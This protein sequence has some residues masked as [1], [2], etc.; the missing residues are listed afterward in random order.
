MSG[1]MR[2]FWI[3]LALSFAYPIVQYH[4]L[5]GLPWSQ[6]PLSTFNKGM[7]LGSILF[8]ALSY[9]AGPAR[10]LGARWAEGLLPMRKFLGLTGFTLAAIHA[11][12]SLLILTPSYYA[13]FFGKDGK[14][15]TNAELALLFGVLAFAVFAVVAAASIPSMFEYLGKK[16]WLKVQQYGYLG[17]LLVLLH[18]AAFGYAG[19]FTPANWQ[20]GILPITLVGFIIGAIALLLKILATIFGEKQKEGK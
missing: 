14:F 9:F 18:A 11:C 1:K 12:I 8:I 3:G 2:V 13:R 10:R 16:Q 20:G 6:F 19:W 5:R 4:F 7:A 15:V 17:V